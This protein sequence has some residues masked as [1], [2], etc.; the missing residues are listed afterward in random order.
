MTAPVGLH[1]DPEH[2][3]FGDPKPIAWN[4]RYHVF[5]QNAPRPDQFDAMRWAHVVSDDLLRWRRLPDALTPDAE[6]PDRCGCWTGSVVRH[7]GVFHAFYTGVAG[8]DGHGQSVCRAESDDLIHWRKDPGNPLV[9]PAAPFATGPDAAWRDPQVRPLPEGGFEMVLTADTAEGPRSLRGCVA[10]LTSSDLRRWAVD[11]LLYHP[12]DVHRCECPDVVPMV[13]GYALLYSSYGVALRTSDTPRGPWRKP[14]NALLDDFR[15]Y[16]AKTT[17]VD[18]RRLMFGF[19][20]DRRS[21]D[22]APGDGSPWTWGGVMAFPRELTLDGVGA[23][24]LRPVAELRALRQDPVALG[25]DA[26]VAVTGAWSCG[27]DGVAGEARPGRE[28]L[29]VARMG[30]QPQQAEI[31]LRIRWAPDGTAGLLLQADAALG[32]GYL[33]ELDRAR[34]DVGLRRLFPHANPASVVLQRMELPP[35]LDDEIGLRAFLDRTV[36]ELFIDDRVAFSAR[37]Y[38][39]PSEAW[40]GLATRGRLWTSLPEVWRLG[41]AP[42]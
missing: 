5:F 37:L 18:G 23:P 40:W 13:S 14:P 19:L 27:D 1:F 34:R 21:Q 33:V 29:A 38:Q 25:F 36:L 11:G 39:R 41:M 9:V 30:R 22:G 24:A 2:G 15:Y 4:G 16:A 8:P 10:R 35:D 32:Q 17:S 6:G 42:R 20:F 12:G 31:E 7:E 3:L 28:E 26:N